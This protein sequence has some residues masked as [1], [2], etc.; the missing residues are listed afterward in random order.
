MLLIYNRFEFEKLLD[1]S[2]AI[3]IIVPIQ[4]LVAGGAPYISA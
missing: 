1:F 2:S 4:Q 3:I